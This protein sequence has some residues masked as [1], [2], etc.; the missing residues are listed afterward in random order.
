M[1]K[2]IITHLLQAVIVPH[3]HFHVIDGGAGVAHHIVPWYARQIKKMR[4]GHSGLN[5]R[6]GDIA[7]KNLTL[8]AFDPNAADCD[9]LSKKAARQGLDHRFYPTAL[10][11]KPGTSILHVSEADASL[12]ATNDALVSRW[13]YGD[14]SDMGPRMRPYQEMLVPVTSIDEWRASCNIPPID[15]IKLNVQASELSIL[16]GCEHSLRSVLGLQLE[17]SFVETYSGQPLFSDLDDYVRRQGFAFFDFLAPNSIGRIHSPLAVSQKMKPRIDVFRW[18]SHQIFEGHFLWLR[19][20]IAQGQSDELT[21]TQVLKLA[22]FA[23]IY[24][25]V[26]YAFELLVWVADRR[27]N[28]GDPGGAERMEQL[29]RRAAAKYRLMLPWYYL[30][31]FP[32][33]IVRGFFGPR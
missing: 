3:D 7:S 6:F 25:Q 15:F 8:Y 4:A 31:A 17:A 32:V 33:S 23:E 9:R 18:P 1:R 19:D 24:G 30:R 11:E 14:G 29:I 2:C 16:K 27:R 22:C 28:A 21:E 10:G 26:E 13:R 12:F 20:P 5:T